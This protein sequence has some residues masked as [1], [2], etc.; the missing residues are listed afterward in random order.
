LV[1]HNIDAEVKAFRSSGRGCECICWIPTWARRAW[2][3]YYIRIVATHSVPWKLDHRSSSPLIL[4]PKLL[5]QHVQSWYWSVRYTQT[6]SWWRIR[7]GDPPKGE[8][9][10]GLRFDTCD[11]V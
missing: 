11:S 1:Y 6:T 7:R 9:K 2:Q 3:F 5:I 10:R 4:F 8:R